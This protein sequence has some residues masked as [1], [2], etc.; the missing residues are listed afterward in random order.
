MEILAAKGII[1]VLTVRGLGAAFC[2]KEDEVIESLF[3]NKD[4][5]SLITL[6]LHAS[7]N[8]NSWKCR[9]IPIESIRKN[10]L[11]AR[12]Q[13]FETESGD[14]IEFDV[15]NNKALIYSA[16][17]HL[18]DLF[19][20]KDYSFKYSINEGNITEIK[21]SPGILL[22]KHQ[23]NN[24]AGY[25]PLE[26]LSVED[27]TLLKSFKTQS[28]RNKQVSFMELFGEKLLVKQE[29]ENLQIVDV[30]TSELIEVVDTEFFN[31]SALI[32]LYRKNLF[33]CFQGT[34]LE[35]W[36]FHGELFT[37]FEDHTLQH[38]IVNSNN[39]YI[40]DDQEIIISYCKVGEESYNEEEDNST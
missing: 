36:S 7:D 33:M 22:L 29:N 19:D 25:V 2:R 37:S 17:N 27:G 4:D 35:V 26:M 5:E 24:W 40:T 30:R 39:I 12:Y 6:S 18:Y 28:Y 14:T 3:Y 15:V 31:P 16:R 38:G 32:F 8:S 34:K 9:T 10:Q 11:R 21:I 23:R 1:F 20:M 13:L